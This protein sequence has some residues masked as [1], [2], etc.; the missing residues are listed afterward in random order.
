MASQDDPGRRGTYD[1]QQV[2]DAMSRLV[3]LSTLQKRHLKEVI[4]P[5]PIPLRESEIN[6]ETSLPKVEASST[7]RLNDIDTPNK[8]R[9]LKRVRAYQVLRKAQLARPKHIDQFV[10]EERFVLEDSPE[11]I[12]QYF[13]QLRRPLNPYR[14]NRLI[15]A[16]A[17]PD[18]CRI[19]V[20]VSR[21]ANLPER[22]ELKS[23]KQDEEERVCAFVEV[24][25]Q[26]RKARTE[27]KLGQ[28]PQ[29]NELIKLNIITED[30]YSPETLMDSDISTEMIYVNLFDE[31]VIDILE[32]DRTREQFKHERI[33]KVWLGSVEIPFATVWERARVD[34]SFPIEVPSTLLQYDRKV[35]RNTGKILPS[36]VQIFITLDPPLLQPQSL[37]VQF[38]SEEDPKLLRHAQQWTT[39]LASYNR[40]VL[41][42]CQ[43]MSGKTV[44][45]PR[46]I[47]PQQPPKKLS[48][49]NEIVRYVSMIPFLANRSGFGAN[50]SLWSTSEQILQVGSADGIEH[51]ILLCNFLLAKEVPAW[52]VMG[53][54]LI[55]GK[56]A[57]VLVEKKSSDEFVNPSSEMKKSRSWMQGVNIFASKASLN[58]PCGFQ[59]YQPVTGK[60]FDVNDR[61]C[62]L[63]QVGCVFN[64]ENVSNSLT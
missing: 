24:S 56:T 14:D 17:S 15:N 31:Q 43:N 10:H 12:M 53:D 1:L 3:R 62:P 13:F 39:S 64:A 6:E 8:T 11:L 4:F 9:F 29:W 5:G 55:D 16:T 23:K 58:E 59:I 38:M 22:K 47:R 25:F 19:L 51:A 34:G 26:K 46:F 63:L 60:L 35:D 30:D 52:V 44:F 57:Y 41:A 21:A 7:G 37:D 20:Q 32:D 28:N 42:L 48:T 36:T 27:T 50:C 33:E 54:D 2:E 45:I 18:Q 61:Y 49:I 40:Y